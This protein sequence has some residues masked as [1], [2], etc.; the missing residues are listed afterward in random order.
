MTEAFLIHDFV[1][2]NEWGHSLDDENL[3]ELNEAMPDGY[4][5][6]RSYKDE[7]GFYLVEYTEEVDD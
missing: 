6:V 5:W 4:Q 2:A 3:Q 7:R 1:N